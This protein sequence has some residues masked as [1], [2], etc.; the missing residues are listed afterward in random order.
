MTRNRAS[1]Q[2][3]FELIGMVSKV[4]E[5]QHPELQFVKES[6]DSEQALVYGVD[7]YKLESAIADL[8]DTHME[9][10]Y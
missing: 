8:I 9:G 7:Y 3:A 5:S 4:I 10:K 6:D 1:E 2:L